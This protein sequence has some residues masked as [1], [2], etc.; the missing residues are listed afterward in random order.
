VVRSIIIAIA[1]A[2]SVAGPAVA[3]QQGAPQTIK[4]SDVVAK[5]DAGFAAADTNHDGFLSAAEMQGEQNKEL[6]N[7]RSAL[8]AK[9]RAAFNQLDTNKDGQ[10]SFAEFSASTLA[11]VKPTETAAQLVQKLDS[12]HDGKVS[13]AEFKAPRLS[14]FDAADA[15]H[16]GIVTQAEAQAYAR[17]HQQH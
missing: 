15:N 11:S 8:E 13:A 3:A 6:Q 9:I 17:A 14:Q 10:L 4:R 12:N 5:L 7:V 1:A 16:D 2:A